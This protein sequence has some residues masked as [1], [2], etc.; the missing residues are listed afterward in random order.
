MH[1]TNP[2]ALIEATF[3]RIETER[4]AGMP[5]LN[6]RLAVAAVG[7]ERK[8]DE[9][10]GALLTPWGIN[11][12]LLPAVEAWPMPASHERAFRHYASGTFAFLPNREDGLGDYLTCPLINDMSQFADQET[13]LLAARA[14]L[15]AVDMPPAQVDADPAAPASSLRRKWLALGS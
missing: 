2:S 5:M 8:D 9:W 14:C 6:A 15:I 4:W 3:R 11:L 12:L 13:A 7:F 10:R 1:A